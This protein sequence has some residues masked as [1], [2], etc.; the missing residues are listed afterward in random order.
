MY[1]AG[2]AIQAVLP[3]LK[4][5]KI[6]LIIGIVVT[7]LAC[8][9]GVVTKLMSFIAFYALLAVPVGA[10]VFADFYFIPK[11]GLKQNYAE[12]SGTSFSWI[13]AVTWALSFLVAKPSIF[14]F[15][16]MVW[17]FP[18]HSRMVCFCGHLHDLKLF[19]SKQTFKNCIMRIAL[20]ILSFTGLTLTI[21]P[22]FL[23]FAGII[24]FERHLELPPL[25]QFYTFPL[26]HF[27]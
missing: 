14:I 17:N 20:I 13:V 10:V 25:V 9:P 1:R 21:L 22:A 7:L 23:H 4:R 5:W 3:A 12:L 11:L 15:R 27:G 16:L 18:G 26:R 2:L 6:T 24:E 8:F 19:L